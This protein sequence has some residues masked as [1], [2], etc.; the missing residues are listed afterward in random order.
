MRE[1]E[2]A[3]YRAAEL[4]LNDYLSG[5]NQPLGSVVDVQFIAFVYEMDAD[6][7][8]EDIRNTYEDMLQRG[9]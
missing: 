6:E 2:E 9:A 5:G 7:V 8:Y 3:I 1:Y 4:V